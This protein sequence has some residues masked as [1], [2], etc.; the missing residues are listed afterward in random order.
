[1]ISDSPPRETATAKYACCGKAYLD[2]HKLVRLRPKFL[3]Q[4]RK[5]HGIIRERGGHIVGSPVTGAYELQL[6]T[7]AGTGRL[8]CT[9][10][11]EA[12]LILP[13]VETA[14]SRRGHTNHTDRDG[15]VVHACHHHASTLP[16][17]TQPTDGTRSCRWTDGPNL[18]R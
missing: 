11:F 7:A 14:I 3:S 6:E 15:P 5:G 2:E 8:A 18:R 13:P 16:S 12:D 10:V 9:D 1:M 17:H 4:N